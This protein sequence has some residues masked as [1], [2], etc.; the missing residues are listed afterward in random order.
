MELF[1]AQP[2]LSLQIS[3]PSGSPSST[4]RPKPAD[5]SIEV[6]LWTKP[7]LDRNINNSCTSS[8][9]FAAGVKNV[10]EPSACDLSLGDPTCSSRHSSTQHQFLQHPHLP[11]PSLIGGLHQSHPHHL[12]LLKPINGIPVYNRP[13]LHNLCDSSFASSASLFVRTQLGL[14]RA[15]LSRCYLPSRLLLGKRGVRAPRMRWTPTLHTRFVHAVEL[16]GGH[17]RATPKSVLELMD[18]KDL[19]LAHVKSHLQMHRTVK[20]T[21]HRTPLSSGQLDGFE[22]GLSREVFDVN[23]PERPNLRTVGSFHGRES[24]F[25]DEPTANNAETFVEDMQAKSKLEVFSDLSP[26]KVNLEFTLGRPR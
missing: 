9:P 21:D 20:N 6:G 19:T 5:E 22:N 16:L 4:W 24:C 1:S 10:G 17:E 7:S 8:I 23:S 13:L 3:P 14:P 18:V 12:C 15:S 26:S 25:P 2:E 11:V